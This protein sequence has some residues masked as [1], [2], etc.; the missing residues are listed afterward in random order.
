MTNILDYIKWRGDLSFEKDPLNDIDALIFARLSYLDFS[1]IIG[2]DS[3]VR[4]TLRSALRL[5][6][7]GKPLHESDPELL[8][9]TGE[10]IRF[11][12]V[13]VTLFRSIF[14]EKEQLQF[15]AVTF[16]CDEGDGLPVPVVAFRGTDSTFTGWKEDFNMS[17]MDRIPAQEEAA[18]YARDVS[19]SFR[20]PLVFTGHAKGGNL[21]V[22]ASCFASETVRNRARMVFNFDG[23]GFND[24]VLK[25]DE[26]GSMLPKIKVIVPQSSMIGTLLGHREFLH[27]IKSS[28]HGLK[29]HDLYTWE[30]TGKTLT[31]YGTLSPVGM[32]MRDSFA[33]WLNG[34]DNE[35]REEFFDAVYRIL[36]NTNSGTLKE[37]NSNKI[38]GIIRL[39]RSYRSMDE[40]SKTVT[41]EVLKDFMRSV[42]GS[43]GEYVGEM[44]NR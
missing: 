31:E 26:Y 13:Q 12:D 7:G 11:G 29:Q 24:D 9:L 27:V 8:R 20:R 33:Q 23:P 39:Y 6:E 28:E 30:V 36:E 17:F 14:D 15:S 43:T 37:L 34:L 42:L 10:S 35:K 44:R 4:V 2:D 1:K 41:T 3:S 19:K 18:R 32:V 16:L 21:S 40:D 25:S 38:K 5:Y 22:Y